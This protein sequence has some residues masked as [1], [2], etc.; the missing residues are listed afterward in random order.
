VVKNHTSDFERRYIITRDVPALSQWGGYWLRNPQRRPLTLMARDCLLF[1]LV[2]GCS[3]A[4]RARGRATLANRAKTVPVRVRARASYRDGRAPS[5]KGEAASNIQSF[6]SARVE[7]G[8]SLGPSKKSCDFRKMTDPDCQINKMRLQKVAS[9][10]YLVSGVAYT[11]TNT[12]T[13][14]S[15]GRALLVTGTSKK[16]PKMVFAGG[17]R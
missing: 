6:Q 4:L 7:N 10:Q 12:V 15:R 11:L 2:Y 8:K 13:Y 9:N 16:G 14:R 5:P 1:L 17:E 3:F